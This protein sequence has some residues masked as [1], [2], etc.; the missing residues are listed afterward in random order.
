MDVLRFIWW[1]LWGWDYSLRNV[2]GW[3]LSR[4]FNR[5][6]K[7]FGSAEWASL[8]KVALGGAWGGRGG[9]IVGKFRGR[10]LRFK[11]D[12]A[13][14]CAAPMGSG[15]GVGIV[16]P[17]LLDYPGAVVCTDPKGENA[18]ITGNYRR[19][20]G[21]V[22]KLDAITP[23]TSAQ[24]NPMDI[25]RLD[26]ATE[27]DDALTLADLLVLPE[28]S[29]AHWDTSAKN[30][31]AACIMW[32][33]RTR[34][35]ELRTLASVAE[36][37][38]SEAHT[39]HDTF[40]LMAQSAWP[41]I[42]SQG[43][44]ALRMLEHDEFL[45]V[46]SNTSK[47]L[48]IWAADRI[49]GRLSARSDFDMMDL[50][51]Q[52]MTVYVMVPEE[53]LA[54]YGPYL[55]VMMGCAITALVRGKGLPRPKHKPLLLLDECQNLGRLD[56]LARGVS[57][58]RE[59]ARTIL[60]FQD[61]GRMR[62]LYGEDGAQSFKAASGAQVVFSV[63]DY[64]TARDFADIIGQATVRA[65]SAGQSQANTDLLRRHDQQGVS[66]AGRYL[67]DGSE[68]MRMPQRKALVRLNTV[69]APIYAGKVKYYRVWR[70]WGRY[71]VW[72]ESATDPAAVPEPPRGRAAVRAPAQAGAPVSPA[73]PPADRPPALSA[74]PPA[75]D[76]SSHARP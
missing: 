24:F 47:A 33:L 52:T 1:L 19:K 30:V 74:A 42:A 38:S 57:Y 11:G 31:L 59:Y 20:L 68:I 63:N 21:P 5:K 70:W 48:K 62:A 12:G 64:Q 71:G 58:L 67:M 10:L 73:I 3:V 61:F 27:F 16:I 13:V 60:I 6:P 9:L 14:L 25:V 43:R 8:W 54:V 17:N 40:T 66:D 26:A 56:A 2:I 36:L 45:S 18:A 69:R 37:V 35:P 72:R 76:A 55:R 65:R 44:D 32:V 53:L 7:T 4:A 51:R 28:S 49:A 23:E 50:H 46:L 22:F 15:K 34:P 75:P 41:S 39:L 29:E